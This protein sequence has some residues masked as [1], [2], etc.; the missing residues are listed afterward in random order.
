MRRVTLFV[1]I[2][3]FGF[4]IA[5]S[6]SEEWSPNK[7]TKDS[8]E[9]LIT[10]GSCAH[11]Y[12]TLKIFDAINEEESDLWIWLGD[13]IYGDSHDMSVLK[14]K[15]D[16]QKGKPQYQKLL[17]N[18]EVIGIW[19]DHDYGI[20]DGG[21]F[22]SKRKESKELLLEF[23]DVSSNDPVRSHEGAYTDYDI[24][25]RDKLIKVIL[26]D[27]RYFR[28]T[29]DIDTVSLARY[30]PNPEGD[31]L[32]EEQWGWLET[33]LKTDGVDFFILG[34]GIQLIAEE[35]G[36]EKWANFPQARARMFELLKQVNASPV[37]FI[38]GDRH[39]AEISKIDIEGVD[40]PIYDFTASGLTHTW[41]V[42]QPEPNM[43]RVDS[44]I[45]AK[46]YGVL[47]INWQGN[48]PS[49]LMEIKGENGELLLRN[50]VDF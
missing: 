25:L 29:L 28:D 32:G 11:S 2:L 47:R 48:T 31:I 42:P 4:S 10:F 7:V 43:H 26:L 40:Y 1:S 17:A 38:S 15:Y 27:T 37:M 36:Y 49:V 23:L 30:I 19:D 14:A 20:N 22:Y 18:T 24:K 13:I 5:C 16:K 3:I 6:T 35:Q 9:V 46:N 45:I 41:G 39:I 34:T 8:N 44:L 50:S 33:K 21:K 12:D